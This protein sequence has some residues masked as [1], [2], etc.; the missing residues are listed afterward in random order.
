ML[1]KAD[2]KITSSNSA[3]T[4]NGLTALRVAVEGQESGIPIQWLY[5]HVGNNDGQQLTFVFT[6]E[7]EVAE[8][9][10]TADQ[11][12]VNQVRFK[13]GKPRQ[14]KKTDTKKRR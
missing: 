8:R 14:S 10:A 3:K 13:P 6:M 9:F 11:T 5:Y 4:L 7:K 1:T 12:L 2:I